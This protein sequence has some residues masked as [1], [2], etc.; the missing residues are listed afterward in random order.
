MTPRSSSTCDAAPSSLAGCCTACGRA[1]KQWRIRVSAA[2]SIVGMLVLLGTIG[3]CGGD[4]T[5]GQD[6]GV[7]A[8]PT[9]TQVAASSAEAPRTSSPATQMA[10]LPT[11]MLPAGLP[12]LSAQDAALDPASND[13]AAA[14]AIG[15]AL[16][17][18][19]IDM[20]GINV[21]VFR[22]NHGGSLLVLEAA[23][24]A[25]AFASS[26]STS[27]AQNRRIAQA[28]LSAP[29]ANI[30]QFAFNI[31]PSNPRDPDIVTL[32][33]PI[34]VLEGIARGTLNEEAAARQI[35][36]GNQRRPSS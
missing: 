24:N 19:G 25:P 27:P 8:V 14:T 26:Q 4:D 32:T 29:A 30:R 35:K 13:E 17:A 20:A 16:R 1:A 5:A 12:T 31:V 22:M 9:S 10:R 2:A 33:G 7:S 11:P 34:S 3:A 6:S 18:A 23:D 36:I 28:L 21:Y 15:D